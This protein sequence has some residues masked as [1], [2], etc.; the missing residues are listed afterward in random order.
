MKKK[1]INKGLNLKRIFEVFLVLVVVVII[2]IMVFAGVYYGF[3]YLNNKINA[4]VV[5]SEELQNNSVFV[6]A[7]VVI[8]TTLM[9]FILM[10]VLKLYKGINSSKK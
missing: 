4:N 8:F 5:A 1:Q 7:L 2:L 6:V 3:G 9:I 10:Q